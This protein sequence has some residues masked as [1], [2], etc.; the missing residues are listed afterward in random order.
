[1]A[2][3]EKVEVAKPRGKVARSEK[4]ARRLNGVSAKTPFKMSKAVFGIEAVAKVPV[5]IQGFI[6]EQS[7]DIV[8]FR[9]K[10]TS[11]SKR[12][13]VTVFNTSDILELFGVPGEPAELTVLMDQ[14]IR[15]AQGTIVASTA[16]GVTIQTTSG[17]QISFYRTA[18]VKIQISAEDEEG[19]QPSNRGPKSGKKAPVVDIKSGGKKKKKRSDDDDEL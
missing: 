18:G 7:K 8:A 16:A 14:T 13:V 19:S 5:S 10:R 11:A 17:E 12:M 15:K 6:V 2:K 4:V 1:M 3:K 9:H